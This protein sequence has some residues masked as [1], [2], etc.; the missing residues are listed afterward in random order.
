MKNYIKNLGTILMSLLFTLS[1]FLPAAFCDRIYLKN[2]RTMEGIIENETETK[3]T[4]NVGFGKITINKNEIESI[5]RYNDQEKGEL[6]EKWSDKYFM[7]PEFIP[8]EFENIARNI[9]RLNL[10]RKRALISKSEKNK[11]LKKITQ[12][13]KELEE[14]NSQLYDANTIIARAKQKGEKREYRVAVNRHNSLVAQIQIKQH[15]RRTLDAQILV[16]DK[17]ISEYIEALEV[18]TQE[19][20]TELSLYD[21]ETETEK[22]IFVIG[23]PEIDIMLSDELPSLPEV[24]R[25]YEIE[26]SEYAI[27][28][29]HPVTTELANL[30][31]NIEIVLDALKASGIN[32]VVLYPNN[33]TG[34]EIIMESLSGLNVSPN[35]RIIPS[36]RFEYFLTLMKNAKAVVGNSSAGIRE[37]PVFGV[38]TINI[39]NRQYNRFNHSSISNVPENKQAILD[40]LT[41]LPESVAPSMYFGNGKSS[42]L[43]ISHLCE[44]KFW[45]LCYQKQFRD[46]NLLLGR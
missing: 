10:V 44:P 43:F 11:I 33:D 17:S 21:S 31:T 26:F 15:D 38:P 4:L 5:R 1:I 27:F 3:I 25:K 6:H 28:M 41:A 35:F 36:I 34:S 29:Y 18:L 39:G 22:S 23:S 30:R 13:D 40:A 20:S 24:K 2:G 8:K 42:K 14:L 16:L 46:L 37:A 45:T 19:V 7:H 12:I 32:Y 9:K